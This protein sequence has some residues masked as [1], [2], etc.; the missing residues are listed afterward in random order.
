MSELSKRRNLGEEFDF[1]VFIDDKLN[2]IIKKVMGMQIKLV[3]K[4]KYIIY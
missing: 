4:N 3:F 1:E 2:S